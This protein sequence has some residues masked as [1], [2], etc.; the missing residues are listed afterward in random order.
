MKFFTAIALIAG[1]QA[2]SLKSKSAIKEDGSEIS[3]SIATADLEE[4]MSEIENLQNDVETLMS[5]P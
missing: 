2:V 1:A 5:L 4:I 3:V